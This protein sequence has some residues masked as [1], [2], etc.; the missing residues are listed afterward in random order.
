MNHY[1]QKKITDKAHNEAMMRTQ[2]KQR[3]ETLG[4]PWIVKQH[5]LTTGA[6]ENQVESR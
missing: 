4:N 6:K 3:V 5:Q 1:G 2:Q